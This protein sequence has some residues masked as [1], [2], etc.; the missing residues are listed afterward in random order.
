[1]RGIS[2]SEKEGVVVRLVTRKVSA[3]SIADDMGAKR[4][5]LYN[6]KRELLGERIPSKMP[7]KKRKSMSVDEL[8]EMEVVLEADID[9]FELKR[10]VL[11][12]RSSS[13][14]KARASIPRYLPTG[15]RPCSWRA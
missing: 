9:R 10:E 7:S 13:W 3:Q 4:G 5:T 2:D 11:E 14:E 1:M 8:E 12:G 15:R 6:W